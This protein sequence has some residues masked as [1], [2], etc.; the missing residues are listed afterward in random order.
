MLDLVYYATD[1]LQLKGS[2]KDDKKVE[3]FFNRPIKHLEGFSNRNPLLVLNPKK[4]LKK[5]IRNLSFPGI[6]RIAIGEGHNILGFISQTKA[7][8]LIWKY[9]DE[10]SDILKFNVRELW[11]EARQTKTIGANETLLAAFEKIRV[12]LVTGLGV[13]DKNGA[14]VGNISVGDLKNASFQSSAHELVNLL[15]SPISQFLQM[16]GEKQGLPMD[17]VVVKLEDSFE[18]LIQKFVE[19]KV[20]RI[21]VVDELKRPLQLLSLGDVLGQFEFYDIMKGIRA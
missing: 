8:E 4:S 10:L 18:T 16:K 15:K 7:V 5:A 19:T 21:Y 14:L 3:E 9:K 11:P 20:K 6:H 2:E 1:K 17:T 12:D 13:V